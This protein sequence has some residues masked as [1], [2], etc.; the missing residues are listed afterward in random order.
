MA[1]RRLRRWRRALL[2]LGMVA[3]LALVVGVPL[4]TTDGVDARYTVRVDLAGGVAEVDAELSGTG[5]MALLPLWLGGPDSHAAFQDEDMLGFWRWRIVF[6]W[7]GDSVRL[8]YS[9]RFGVLG[10]HGYQGRIEP[11]FALMGTKLLMW[12]P[13][14]ARALRSVRLRVEAPEGADV[15]CPWRQDEDGWHVA[16][17]PGATTYNVVQKTAV[18]VGAF[19]R[20]RIEHQGQVQELALHASFEP[21]L[22][23]QVVGRVR[24]VFAHMVDLLGFELRGAYLDVFVPPAGDG[25]RIHGVSWSHG[26]AWETKKDH[27]RTWELLVHRIAHVFNRDRPH[28][29]HMGSWRDSWWVE[30]LASWLEVEIT[31]ALGLARS[32]ARFDRLFRIYW[33]VRSQPG[34][35]WDRAPARD[36]WVLDPEA[37]EW[38]HYFKYPVVVEQLDFA[39]RAAGAEGVPQLFR[40]LFDRYGYH[41]APVPDLRA[42]AEAFCECDLDRFF[43][44]YVDGDWPLLPLWDRAIAVARERA[45]VRPRRRRAGGDDRARPRG[46]AAGARRRGGGARRRPAR[47][48]GRAPRAPAHRAPGLL[49][50]RVPRRHHGLARRPGPL[51]RSALG[52]RVRGAG[53][54]RVDPHRRPLTLALEAQLPT[55][56]A[57]RPPGRGACPSQAIESEERG[58]CSRPGGLILGTLP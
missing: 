28:G 39:L 35:G 1:D 24:K 20:E 44:R 6:P 36:R 41:V 7:W 34:M 8:R 2:G 48:G 15:V 5:G 37:I 33:Q 14:P 19:V 50:L 42:E 58:G 54:P 32:D 49:R 47:G 51:H 9:V 43:D 31:A 26:H 18:A 29:M 12:L 45:D 38:L 27:L 16:D 25:K 17:L 21:A 30:G 22:R 57:P 13:A 10:R 52:G 3:A 11:E 46:R 40:W 56:R 55:G 23:R 53:R 4:L